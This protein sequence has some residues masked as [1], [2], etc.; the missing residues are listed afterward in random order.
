[1][2]GPR[3]D[4]AAD[5]EPPEGHAVDRAIERRLPLKKLR[6]RIRAATDELMSALGER[7]RLWFRLEELIGDYRGRREEAYFDLDYQHGVAAGRAESLRAL[8]DA[9]TA[10]T[11]TGE[12][13]A[14]ADTIRD[15]AVQADLPVP[16][17]V[18][19]LLETAW[20]LAL[21]LP[22]DPA[23]RNHRRT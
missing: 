19:A 8:A 3:P 14:F 18:A 2:N 15:L 7:K 1:M 20:A 11:R 6:R 22:D 5:H 9:A 12:T 23:T 13:R 16:L 4:D 17:T 21:G 10:R